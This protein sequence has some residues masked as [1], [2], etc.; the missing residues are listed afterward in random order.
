MSTEPTLEVTFYGN[1][2]FSISSETT[3]VLVDPYLTENEECPWTAEEIAERERPDAV[4]V[5]HAA[6]DHVGDTPTL[7]SGD[8]L[9]VITEPATRRSLLEAGV[10]DDTVTEVLWGMR[11]R[12]GDLTIRAL[13][14]HHAS[15]TTVDGALATGVPLSFLVTCGDASVYHMG[16]TSLFRDIK[17]FGELYDPDVALL[18]VGQAYDAAAEADGPVTPDI[19]ELSTDEALLAARW[20]GS[21]RIVPM[22][23]LPEERDAFVERLGADGGPTVAPLD[24]GESIHVG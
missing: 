15:V 20:A 18:G 3:T 13:E 22:H 16:D 21:D 7:A 24:P 5:T 8:G 10:S 4:C 6:F 23:Y 9:P 11:A 17:T 2:A 19:S 12:V 14:A 1:A